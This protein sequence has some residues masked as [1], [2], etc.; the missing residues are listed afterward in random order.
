[1]RFASPLSDSEETAIRRFMVDV[2][3]MLGPDL[4]EAC[5]FGSRAR[6]EGNEQS[7]LD[8]ALIVSAEG[9]AR[10]DA[11]YDLAF[12]VGLA[13]GVQLAPLVLEEGRFR[14]LMR[15]ERRIAL[16]IAREGIPV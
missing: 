1:M 5:I 9:R 16:D 7:D 2:R 12:D 8:L 11:L 10:R 13:H 3:T 4:K 14:E 15:R 6:G